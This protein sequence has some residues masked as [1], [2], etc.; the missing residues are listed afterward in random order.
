LAGDRR[1]SIG[2]SLLTVTT[3]GAVIS[4]WLFAA[5]AS[6]T[7]VYQ[8]ANRTRFLTVVRAAAEAGLD[9]V[10][11]DLNDNPPWSDHPSTFDSAT[12]GITNPVIGNTGQLVD[13]SSLADPDANSA[14]NAKVRV[15]VSN[16]SPPAYSSIYN[17]TDAYN[18]RVPGHSTNTNYWRVV[19]ASASYAGLSKTIQV[20]LKPI[21]P[22]AGSS[23]TQTT[24]TSTPPI[25]YFPF[26]MFGVSYL[27]AS[28]GVT[29]DAYDSSASANGGAYG[30]TNIFR[31]SST[32]ESGYPS[33]PKYNVAHVG[34]NGAM[35][36]RGSPQIY[37][38]LISTPPLTGNPPAGYSKWLEVSA[39]STPIKGSIM[40][41]R[42]VSV[43]QWWSPPAGAVANTPYASY[44]GQ[45]IPNGVDSPGSNPATYKTVYSN[46]S[47]L[48]QQSVLSMPGTPAAA[49]VQNPNAMTQTLQISGNVNVIV[50]PGA[51]QPASMNFSSGYVNAQGQYVSTYYIPPG[52]YVV[53]AINISGGGKLTIPSSLAGTT[54]VSIYVSGNT[55]GTT[56]VSVSGAGLVNNNR[57]P[58]MLQI[59]SSSAKDVNISGGGNVS[60]VIYA[61]N[62][63]VAMSGGT[64]LYGAVLANN[65]DDSGGA[66]IHYDALLGNSSSTLLQTFGLTHSVQNTTT[67]TT[68]NM[69]VRYQVISWRELTQTECHPDSGNSS[70]SPYPAP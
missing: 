26:A 19:T 56:A 27:T 63:R 62:A 21:A 9:Y 38:S 11:K 24:S 41:R 23:S 4:I 51:P 67:S 58:E 35:R 8:A 18:P 1:K 15:W 53:S 45:T 59:W 10:V 7:P 36:S 54:P 43:P 48:P 30:G 40:A 61:P 14:F 46:R 64:V 52:N 16:D 22:D 42:T 12:F 17:V 3:L 60:G 65:M 57:Y 69:P 50:Q 5:M 25:S 70:Y 55:S 68:V 33:S 13:I 47:E 37:G 32:S 28:G 31:A 49:N 6:I 66:S 34:S 20:I 39:W 44:D 29:V 2:F